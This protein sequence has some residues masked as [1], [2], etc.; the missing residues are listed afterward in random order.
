MTRYTIIAIFI[1]W[2]LSSFSQ[3]FNTHWICHPL[4]NDSSQVFF[5]HT[6]TT[7]QRPQQ[8]L[9]SFTSSGL[10]KVYFNERNISQDITFCNPDSTVLALYTYD[11]TRF[12]RPDSNT[13]A[14]WYAPDKDYATTKQL[15]LEYYGKDDKGQDFYHHTDGEWLCQELKGCYKHENKETFDGQT[16]HSNWKAT[17]CNVHDWLQPL[18]PHCKSQSF[19]ITC[20]TYPNSNYQ[21]N[22][23]LHPIATYTDSTGIYYDFGRPFKG[24]VR[25]TLREAK[26]GCTIYIDDFTYICNGEM[27]E[28]AFRRFTTSH[29]RSIHISHDKHFKSSQVVNVEALEY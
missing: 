17:D 24:T 28:Q 15:S 12:L 7:S 20:N 19:P 25:L 10:V 22:S 14:V 11:V 18:G 4:A 1:V 5:R 29:Q 21:I 8:A 13:I 16:Y 3:E 6:Y 27:D 26:K 2:V 9:L 23:I